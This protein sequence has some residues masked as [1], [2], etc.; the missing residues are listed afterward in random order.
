LLRQ[1]GQ[2]D[3]GAERPNLKLKKPVARRLVCGDF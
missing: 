2:E 1:Q 3:T